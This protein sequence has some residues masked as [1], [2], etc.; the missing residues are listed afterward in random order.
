MGFYAV[1]D[2][3]EKLSTVRSTTQFSLLTETLAHFRLHAKPYAS[4]FRKGFANLSGLAN[5]D[6]MLFCAWNT[7]VL[8]APLET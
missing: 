7:S 3:V 2:G 4:G 6:W 8:Q 5:S 1:E